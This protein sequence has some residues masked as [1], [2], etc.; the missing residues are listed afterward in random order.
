MSDAL[1][2]AT[3][4]LRASSPTP[5][6]DAEV[7]LAHVTGRE[8]SWLLAHP[9][10]EV[11]GAAFDALIE[12]RADGEPV[13]YIRGFKEWHSLRIQTDGRAL[14]PRPETELLADAAIAE[15]E[16]RLRTGPVVAWEVATGS[17]AVAIA[18]ARHF[19]DAAA[20]PHLI[21]T[22]ISDD[23]L[24]LATENL[25]AHGVADAVT[26]QRADLLEPAGQTLPRP[27]VVIAN[28]PYVASAEVD[29]RKGSLGFEPRIALDGGPDGLAVLRR[30]F[31]DLRQRTAPGATVLLELGVDQ[32]DA[33]RQLAPAGA[34]VTVVPDLAGLDRVVRIGLPDSSS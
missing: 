30:L 32:V 20:R 26:R 10:A 22:D 15:I 34:S 7:L 13:A 5:R 31:A 3:E 16:D 33:I 11:D 4:H 28:L 9:E 24:A 8:R 2:A 29:E 18:V 19:V 12:R 25:A 6:L 1:R 27:D 21:A 23:A 14:I 17:G